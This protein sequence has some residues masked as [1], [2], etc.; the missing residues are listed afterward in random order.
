MISL[1][2]RSSRNPACPCACHRP[3]GIDAK[4][5]CSCAGCP[6]ATGG[7]PSRSRLEPRHPK[8][9]ETYFAWWGRTGEDLRLG[10]LAY[11]DSEEWRMVVAE[12]QA[13]D[14]VEERG[15]DE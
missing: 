7:R 2:P 15:F 10:R 14:I 11:D 3:P 13:T 12:E 1:V 4:D 5:G 9:D 6:M 8:D